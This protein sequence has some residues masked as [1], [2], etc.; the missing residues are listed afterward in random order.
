MRKFSII[1]IDNSNLNFQCRSYARYHYERNFRGHD[2]MH[3]Y[4]EIFFVTEG[5]GF[6]HLRDKVVPIHR[7]T[8]IIN[9]GDIQHSESSAPNEEL[10]YA[11][12]GIYNLSFLANHE[13]EGE[14]TFVFDFSKD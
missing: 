2:H 5:S 10:E 14:S 11:V 7:G 6:F 12:L 3:S 13:Y 1:S 9:N 4:S 8:V